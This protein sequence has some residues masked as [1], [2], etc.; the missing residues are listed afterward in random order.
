MKEGRDSVSYQLSSFLIASNSFWSSLVN[1]IFSSISGR[2][3][4]VRRSDCS[5]RH[6]A[7]LP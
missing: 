5:R 1:G 7:I 3:F 4:K 6:L 2:R